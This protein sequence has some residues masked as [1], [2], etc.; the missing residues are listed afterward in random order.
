MGPIDDSEAGIRLFVTG[1]R[2]I[3]YLRWRLT[4]WRER[5]GGLREGSPPVAESV[6]QQIWHHQRI[7]RG[8]LVDTTGRAVR[9]LHPGFWNRE[10]GP[11]F[12]GAIIQFG[13]DPPRQ[14]DVEID[15]G[16]DGW[17]GH[18][19]ANNPAYAKVVL[20]VVWR[21][22]GQEANLPTLEMGRFLDAPVEEL[23]FWLGDS[24]P[25]FP[26]FLRGKCHAPLSFLG[27]QE[28]EGL[29]R[30]AAEARLRDKAAAMQAAARQGGWAQALW[31]ALFSALGYKQ[32]TWPM[33]RLAEMAPSLQGDG[34]SEELLASRLFGVSGLLPKELPRASPE[35]GAEVTRMW[36]MWWRESA[37]WEGRIVPKEAWRWS[38]IRPANH[39]Q[40]RLALAAYWLAQ[41]KL[42]DRLAGWLSTWVEEKDLPESL[43]ELLE[44]PRD[45]PW[46]HRFTL[47]SKQSTT[48]HRLLGRD[49]LGDVAMNV[50]LPWLWL[51]AL[52]GRNEELERVARRRYHAWPASGSNSVVRLAVERLLGG[53]RPPVLKSAA[54]HQGLI[55]IVRDF[56]GRSN[57]LCQHCEFPDLLAAL[58]T[59]GPG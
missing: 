47:E 51:R 55:Q 59:G 37:E 44:P 54:G 11:D 27:D 30:Q 7:K 2:D 43:E 42:P 41:D 34:K 31:E 4:K 45:H 58:R 22:K 46:R 19:H 49:R 17:A 21:S 26:E 40:R 48:P 6:L 39:P 8:E 24:A 3:P 50:V 38:H 9:V 10:S 5:R 15:L 29:L 12:L 1:E 14:G 36:E 53:R 20:H 35:A 56:C 32:N 33:R 18:G 25:A 57:S 13:E 16:N 52:A 28:L 23:E